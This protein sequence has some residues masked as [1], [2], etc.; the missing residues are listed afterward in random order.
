MKKIQSVFWKNKIPEDRIQGGDDVKDEG[1][2]A[3]PALEEDNNCSEE[4]RLTWSN[5]FRTT[6]RNVERLGNVNADYHRSH[7]K[8]CHCATSE[9]Q[10]EPQLREKNTP[11]RTHSSIAI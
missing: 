11:T 3:S 8:A 10:A 4:T 1:H 9:Y 5:H 2:L 6:S 7:R